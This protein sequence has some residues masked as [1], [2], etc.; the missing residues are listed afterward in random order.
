[1]RKCLIDLPRQRNEPDNNF[2]LM[3]TPKL[4]AA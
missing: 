1:M 4:G 3:E 2:L